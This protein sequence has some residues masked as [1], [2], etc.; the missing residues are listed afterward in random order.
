MSAG[1]NRSEGNSMGSGQRSAEHGGAASLPWAT[2]RAFAGAWG[3]LVTPSRWS[4]GRLLR[5]CL[6]QGEDS[7]MTFYI[8][9]VCDF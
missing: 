3:V 9:V 5:E 8:R 1:M 6:L 4:S 2:I 7:A